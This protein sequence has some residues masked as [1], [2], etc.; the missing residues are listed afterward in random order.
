M[1]Q[2]QI[3]YFFRRYKTEDRIGDI[4]L[5]TELTE[6]MFWNITAVV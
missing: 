6:A 5:N 1:I 4:K 2:I 3:A